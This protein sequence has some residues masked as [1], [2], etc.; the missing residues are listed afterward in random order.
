MYFK[1]SYAE[2]F[3][4]QLAKNLSMRLTVIDFDIITVY[5]NH[6]KFIKNLSPSL[7]IGDS[8]ATNP[9]ERE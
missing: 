4:A 2:I 5:E 3:W 9:S 6:A 7:H 1:L 8:M